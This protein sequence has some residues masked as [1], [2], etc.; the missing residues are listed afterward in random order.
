MIA[1]IRQLRAST[2]EILSAVERGDTVFIS[3]RGR[4]CAKIVPV[5]HKASKERVSLA[6]L[7]KNN[8]KIGS[9]RQF[10]SKLRKPRHDH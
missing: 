2:K 4:T 3:N 1:N 5:K 6:G 7:W 8:K 9:V 10:I